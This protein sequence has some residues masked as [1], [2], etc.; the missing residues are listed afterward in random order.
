MHIIVSWD[1]KAPAV[2]QEEINEQLRSAIKGYSWARPMGS[3]FIVRVSDNDARKDL[4]RKLKDIAKQVP[5]TVHV[6]ISPG[7][8]GGSYDGWLPK[9]MWDKIN[10]RTK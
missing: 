3:V 2:R 9:R 1:I 7:M 6:L 5:E 8:V 4:G 10:E